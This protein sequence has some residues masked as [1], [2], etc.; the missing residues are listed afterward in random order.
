MVAST[1]LAG[2]SDV[3]GRERSR[4]NSRNKG[5]GNGMPPVVAEE[6]GRLRDKTKTQNSDRPTLCTLI[7]VRV[8]EYSQ[9][10]H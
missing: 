7:S 5:G 9:N 1:G 3:T 8:A 10:F 4:V 6:I 2:V